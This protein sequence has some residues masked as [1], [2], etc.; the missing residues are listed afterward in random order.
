VPILD[1]QPNAQQPDP[2]GKLVPVPPQDVL[3]VIGPCIPVTV[4]V[5]GPIVQ[6]LFQKG[7]KV[8]KPI[9][10]QDLIDTGASSTC[11]DE[12]T[13]K[14]LK[15]FARLFITAIRV[16]TPSRSERAP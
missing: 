10:G 4:G 3:H 1:A 7:E 13:A 2:S 8:P 15:G 5:A 16:A 9:S 11:I 6:Q 12:T 14:K